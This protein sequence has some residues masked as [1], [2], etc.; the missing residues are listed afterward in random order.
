M[1][2]KRSKGIFRWIGRD[3]RRKRLFVGFSLLFESAEG[4]RKDVSVGTRKLKDCELSEGRRRAGR[5]DA[6][7]GGWVVGRAQLRSLRICAEGQVDRVRELQAH[8]ERG[9]A[10]AAARGRARARTRGVGGVVARNE[11]DGCSGY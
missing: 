11:E 7:D 9:M 2:R 3:A 10:G 8:S 4:G 6:V 5:A 1:D